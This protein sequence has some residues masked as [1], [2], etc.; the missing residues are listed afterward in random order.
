LQRI[1]AAPT[2]YIYPARRKE[3]HLGRIVQAINKGAEETL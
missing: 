3:A 2:R 1:Q